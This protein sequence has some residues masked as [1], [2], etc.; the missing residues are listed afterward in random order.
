LFFG[1]LILAYWTCRIADPMGFGVAARHTKIVIGAVNTA[2]LL[3]SSFAVAWAVTAARLTI[4]RMAAILLT[5]AALLGV[6]FLGLKALEYRLEYIEHMLPG[7]GFAFEGPHAR[8]ALQFFSI[9]FVATG[10][11]ALHVAIGIVVL[12]VIAQRASRNAYSDRYH[13]PI[14]VAGLYW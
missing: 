2:I 14:T 13:A 12:G 8:T 6:I 4:G 7:L 1:C 5:I 10:L 11:H 3:T 9:Y